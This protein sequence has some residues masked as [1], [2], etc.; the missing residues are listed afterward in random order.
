MPNTVIRYLSFATISIAVGIFLALLLIELTLRLIWVPPSLKT[1]AATEQHTVYGWAPKPGVVGLRTTIEYSHDFSHTPQGFRGLGVF[2]PWSDNIDRQRVLFLGDSF[3]YGLGSEDEQTFVSLIASGLGK[4]DV[5]NSGAGGYGQRQELAILDTLGESFRPDLTVLVFFWNDLEDNLNSDQATFDT[6]VN[7][8]VVRTD[9]VVPPSFDPLA[10]KTAS[11][12]GQPVPNHLLY[13]TRALV[14]EGLKAF[15]Y[16]Y[17][18]ISSRDI[19]TKGQLVEAWEVTRQLLHL[20]SRRAQELGSKLL[21]VSIPDHN[22]VNPDAYIKN[23][24]PIN[25]DIEAELRRTTESL[26][27]RYYD[28]FND[29]RVAYESGRTDLYFYADRHLTPKGN[30]VVAQALT[31]VIKDLLL[32]K[33]YRKY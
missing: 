27:I 29:F 28:L 6:D 15:R 4:V 10:M 32:S 8:N 5:I 9:L 30:E 2:E 19:Q 24:E 1:T 17:Y 12:I 18:G 23:I 11:D 31:P 21:V 26:G 22:K 25:F 7:G 20:T 3:T 13:Y 33:E 14:K 16:R